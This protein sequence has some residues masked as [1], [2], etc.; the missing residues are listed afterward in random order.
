MNNSILKMTSQSTKTILMVRPTDFEFN[1]QTAA[2]NEF[3][4]MLPGRNVRQEALNEFENA[5]SL[6]RAE[7]VQVLILE[8]DPSLPEMPDAVFPN[9]WFGTDENGAIHIF[10][11]KTPNRQQEA[12]QITSVLKLLENEGF[13]FTEILDWRKLLGENQVLEGTGSLILDRVHKR[14]FAAISD[15]T[16]E[17]ACRKFAAETDYQPVLFHTMSSRGFAYYHTN[18]VMSIGANV[19]VACLEC[20]P[21]SVEREMVK[22]EIIKHHSLVEISIQQLEEGFCG[23]LLQ[24]LGNKGET[25]TVLSST[26]FNSLS[27]EQKETLSKHGKL[28]PIPIPIIEAVGGGSIRCMMAEI[29]CP[30]KTG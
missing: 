1:A 4:N 16:Q 17:D 22:N 26:A 18:V 28:I 14:M 7:G 10:P 30:R 27:I 2:D 8:K 23:N 12:D 6:L 9:N 24:V 20:I 29:F 3:Q 21:D 11:M 19:V 13:S 15:R 25:I 5:V